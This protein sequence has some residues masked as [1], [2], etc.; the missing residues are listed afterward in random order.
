MTSLTVDGELGGLAGEVLGLVVVGEGD[1]DRALLAGAGALEL[2]LEAG[3]QAAGA[4]LEQVAAGLAA[5]ERLAVDAC[6]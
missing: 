1:L 5:L 2:L 6:R 3:D 4:E